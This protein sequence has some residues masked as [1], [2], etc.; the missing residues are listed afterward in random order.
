MI[1]GYPHEGAGMFEV[2]C[3]LVEKRLERNVQSIVV[4]LG[5]FPCAT[6]SEIPQ[7]EAIWPRTA[8]SLYCHPIRATDVAVPN[9]NRK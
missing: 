9:S 8:L 2:A 7:T 4:S 5:G 6:C 3:R 1:T